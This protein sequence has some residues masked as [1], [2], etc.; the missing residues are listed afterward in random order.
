M[1]RNILMMKGRVSLAAAVIVAGA[2]AF[3]TSVSASGDSAATQEDPKQLISERC[4]VCHDISM[5]TSRHGSSEE[6]HEIV[7]RMV[8]NGA[9]VTEPQADLIANYLARTQGPAAADGHS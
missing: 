4:T 2:V 3:S 9:D 5:V 7:Q 1:E 8:S 6:W